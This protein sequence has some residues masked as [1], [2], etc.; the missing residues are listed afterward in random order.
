[1]KRQAS[2]RDFI[3]D[4]SSSD[5]ESLPELD[6]LR[7]RLARKR[8][9]NAQCSVTDGISQNDT[10][11][12]VVDRKTVEEEKLRDL[13]TLRREACGYTCTGLSA[14]EKY[15][16]DVRGSS[17]D[18]TEKL[19]LSQIIE[20]SA[21]CDE[22]RAESSVDTP[23]KSKVKKKRTTEEI[24]ESRKKAQVAGDLV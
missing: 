16:D 11:Q 18:E 13:E 9:L 10:E 23:I 5:D 19:S 24:E 15:T 1:M 14:Q 17:G 8:Q 2:R 20:G 22:G 3:S 12:F 6:S 4:S 7:D 21:A